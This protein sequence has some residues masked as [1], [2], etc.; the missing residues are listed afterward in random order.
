MD[1]TTIIDWLTPMMALVCFSMPIMAAVSDLRLRRKGGTI[2]GKSFMN[3]IRLFA[4]APM[5]GSVA[6]LMLI[7]MHL[8]IQDANDVSDGAV[9]G[10]TFYL[11]VTLFATIICRAVLY[12]RGR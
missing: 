3:R 6:F 2:S 8:P 5:L 9:I 7:M 11:M 12:K 10:G 4:L 1:V